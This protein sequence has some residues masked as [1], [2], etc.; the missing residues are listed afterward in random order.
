[1]VMTS[2]KAMRYVKDFWMNF[3]IKMGHISAVICLDVTFALKKVW[4]M[5]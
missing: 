4:N 3:K 1:M 5:Q 2:P